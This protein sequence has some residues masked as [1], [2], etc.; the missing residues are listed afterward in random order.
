MEKTVEKIIELRKKKGI[1]QEELAKNIGVTFSC[2]ALW[3]TKKR[4]I[5]VNY[6]KKIAKYFDVSLDYLTGGSSIQK[7]EKEKELIDLINQL[8]DEQVQEISTFIDYLISKRK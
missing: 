4:K 3:E 8:N 2:V 1:T 7:T 5:N 6:L